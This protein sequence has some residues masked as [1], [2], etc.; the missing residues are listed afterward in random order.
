MKKNGTIIPGLFL[1]LI[2]AGCQDVDETRTAEQSLTAYTDNSPPRVIAVSPAEDAKNV[3]INTE[4]VTVTFSEAID[5]ASLTTAS[6]T[7]G[8]MPGTVSYSNSTASFGSFGGLKSNTTY[9]ATITT[10]VKDLAGNSITEPYSWKFSTGTTIDET[11]PYVSTVDPVDGSTDVS[12]NKRIS[13]TFNKD[14]AASSFS[15]DTFSLTD[16]TTPTVG[17]VSYTNKIA[18]LAPQGLYKKK[19]RDILQY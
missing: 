3:P 4:V 10:A 13:V 7:V 16:G 18:T 12:T 5:E 2:L 1:L 8:G 19:T 15:T 17:S 6:F 14:M 9:A 11:A